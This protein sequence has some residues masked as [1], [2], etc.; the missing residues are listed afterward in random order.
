MASKQ[1]VKGVRGIVST[2]A[3]STLRR[4]DDDTLLDMYDH[5]HETGD[6]YCDAIAAEL[7]WRGIEVPAC[8]QVHLRGFVEDSPKSA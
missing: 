4:L 6:E 1:P 2:M 5:A 3:S 8:G 7:R